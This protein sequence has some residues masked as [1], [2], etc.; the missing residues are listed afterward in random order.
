MVEA[1][2][3][4]EDERGWKNNK[5]AGLSSEE[6]FIE[7]TKEGVARAENIEKVGKFGNYRTKIASSHIKSETKSTLTNSGLI[8]QIPGLF[9]PSAKSKQIEEV[10]VENLKPKA[11]DR[12]GLNL[13]ADS[14]LF[15]SNENYKLI[16]PQSADVSNDKNRK[17]IKNF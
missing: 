14:L 5:H 1:S 12:V 10:S 2:S 11:P 6:E 13:G 4:S 17:F 9:P 3:A 8:L 16:R 7:T 15:K